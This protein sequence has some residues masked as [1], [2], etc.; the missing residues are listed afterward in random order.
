MRVFLSNLKL[1][2]KNNWNALR[3]TMGEVLRYPSAIIG[4]VMIS[5]LVIGSLYAVIGLPYKE[6]GEEW[7]SSGLTGKLT[8]PKNVPAVWFNLFR[9]HD[10]PTTIIKN[11]SDGS[12]SKTVQPPEDDLQQID[13]S[14]E[15]DYQY[16]GFPQDM[17]LNITS[18]YKEKRPHVILT[19]ITPDGREF[20]PK[21]PSIESDNTYVFSEYLDPRIYVLKN[22][23]W[24][25]WFVTTGQNRTPEFY[26]LFADP[27]ADEAIALPGKYQL[28][29]TALTFEPDTDMDIEFVLLGQ[30]YGWAGTDYLRR[31]L[32]VP[33]LWGLPFALAFGLIG[34]TLI[35]VFAMIIAAVGVW[36]GGWVDNLIQRF[37]E[38]TMIIPI[39]AVGV[40]MHALYNISL[41]TILIIV[42]IFYAFSS[43]TKVFR[44]AL[45][46]VKEAPYIEAAHAYGSSNS[47]IIFKYM[48]P[49]IIPVLIPQLVMLI[50]ALVFLEATLGIFNVYDPRYPTWGRV[51]YEALTRS[52]L[53]GGSAY[54]VLEPISL[55]LLTGLAFALV[56]FALERILN[57]RLQDL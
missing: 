33:L 15:L 47:R 6:I 41:W 4:L 9:R 51:I 20:Y 55:L 32:L 18:H 57:P 19:W 29:V 36:F 42:V 3:R 48:I 23:A 35:T 1:N 2:L 26:A 45:I 56:G 30:V 7:R 39:L 13:F 24:K 54:W 37:T 43:P 53:W 17:L 31:D 25:E 50:P 10:Y 38:M 44:A 14:M 27:E 11:S 22:P 49:K 12:I 8:V 21:S 16:S 52:A 40:L 28:Q 46:Q 34:A 5:V